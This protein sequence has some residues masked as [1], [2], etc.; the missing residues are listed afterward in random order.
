MKISKI[1]THYGNAALARCRFCL[2]FR[3]S[4]SFASTC[5]SK[6]R[7]SRIRGDSTSRKGFTLIEIVI[8]LLIIALVIGG[9]IA[10]LAFNDSQRILT[11]QSGE[12]EMLAKKARTAA[13]LHQTPYVIEFHPNSIK[14]LPLSQASELER[15]TA[16][17]NEIGGRSS[18]QEAR[19]R[20]NET[21]KID[22][23]ITLTIRHW[24][25]EKFITP[26]ESMIPVWRFDPD[27]LS[28]P[29]TVRLNLGDNSYA[30]DTYHP[31]TAA[32]ADSELEAY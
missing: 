4:R 7:R 32:I 1:T 25:T 17:G 22:P 11:N 2:I 10:A 29:I 13:I 6:P 19:P 31:L 12:I 23:D 20:I 27:G 3:N 30:Q 5:P 18:D 21:I 9:S 15:T 28:E 16:L 24:N 8:V 14:L 26:T